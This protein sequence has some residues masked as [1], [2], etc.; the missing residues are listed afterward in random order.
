MS[1]DEKEY[2]L[3]KH[4]PEWSDIKP[5]PQEDG[6]NSVVQIAYSE[7]FK[8]AYDYF[9]AILAKGE[10]S[11]RALELTATAI[12]LN[13]ANYTVWELRRE[14]LRALN[15]NVAEE[16]ALLS[17]IIMSQQKNYQ[18]WHHRRALVEWSKDASE[19]LKFTAEIIQEDQKNYHAWQHRQWVI[20][21][22]KQCCKH[23][24]DL[25]KCSCF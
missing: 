21:V 5:I 3:Y 19:E 10:K 12:E 16:M 14:I 22:V 9:R 7:K 2:V 20:K 1:D 6:P 17:D 15:K 18:V 11:E 24:R 25:L 13:A 8:D 4:R 23:A